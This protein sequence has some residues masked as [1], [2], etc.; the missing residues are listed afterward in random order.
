MEK[1]KANTINSLTRL[2]KILEKLPNTFFNDCLQIKKQMV[3]FKE[4]YKMDK[5]E[6]TIVLKNLKIE[7]EYFNKINKFMDEKQNR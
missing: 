5:N 7:E 3:Y 2:M 6:E 1:N 4:K